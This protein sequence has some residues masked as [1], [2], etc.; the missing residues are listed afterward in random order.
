MNPFEFI[1]IVVIAGLIYSAWRAKHLAQ[2]GMFEDQGG[3]MKRMEGGER[4]AALQRE[5]EELRERI[6][7]LERIATDDR[8]ANRLSAEIDALRDSAD[9]IEERSKQ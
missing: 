5:V 4:E 9:K 1:L 7:V 2:H 8:G 3:E 6:K